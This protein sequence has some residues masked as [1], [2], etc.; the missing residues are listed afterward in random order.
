MK[1]ARKPPL[2]HT[3]VKQQSTTTN[4]SNLAAYGTPVANGNGS[5]RTSPHTSPNG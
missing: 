5:G 1:I 3:P 2:M 4:N